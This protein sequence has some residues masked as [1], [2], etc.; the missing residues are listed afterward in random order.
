M[1]AGS[2]LQMRLPTCDSLAG[3][4]YSYLVVAQQ[5]VGNVVDHRTDLH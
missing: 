4:S 2:G 1:H 3:E 5:R